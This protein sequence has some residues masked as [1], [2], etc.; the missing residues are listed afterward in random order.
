MMVP[1][2]APRFVLAGPLGRRHRSARIL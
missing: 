1:L 2:L